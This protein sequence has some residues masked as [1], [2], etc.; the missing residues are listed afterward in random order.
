MNVLKYL[1]LV[2]FMVVAAPT[3]LLAQIFIWL[4]YGVM[5]ALFDVY[6]SLSNPRETRLYRWMGWK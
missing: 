2:V 5:Y 1:S 6:L 3:V 4:I